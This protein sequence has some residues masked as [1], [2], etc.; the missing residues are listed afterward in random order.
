MRIE[1]IEKG[2]VEYFE[3]N[4]IYKIVCTYN[5]GVCVF[6]HN[7]SISNINVACSSYNRQ[8]GIQISNDGKKLFVGNWE[9]GLFAYDTLTGILLWHYKSSRIRDIFVYPEYLIILRANKAVEKIDIETGKLCF[10][11][12]SGTA[13]H[14]F[15]LKLPLIFVDKISKKYCIVDTKDMCVMQE[16]DSE[17]IN[18]HE[19]LSMLIRNVYLCNNEIVVEGIESYPKRQFNSNRIDGVDFSR[20]IG[21]VGE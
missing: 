18:P 4:A 13:E 7:D 11:I 1:A 15:Y 12:K 20:V 6:F 3:N 9:K 21:K 17:V 5:A 16:Y 19:C 10:V 14:I 2:F 8:Y